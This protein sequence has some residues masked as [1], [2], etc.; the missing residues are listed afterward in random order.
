[1]SNLS[2]G[3]YHSGDETLAFCGT[4]LASNQSLHLYLTTYSITA[5]SPFRSPLSRGLTRLSRKRKRH[6]ALQL[7]WLFLFALVALHVSISLRYWWTMFPG[8][9]PPLS[10]TLRGNSVAGTFNGAPLTLVTLPAAASTRVHCVGDNYFHDEN[11]AFTTSAWMQRSCHFTGLFCF[12]LTSH[13]FVVYQSAVEQSL[14]RLL[15]Q[16]KTVLGRSFHTSSMVMDLASNNTQTVSLG[17]L[18]QKWGEAGIRRLEW[19]PEVVNISSTTAPRVVYALPPSVVLLPFHS[20]NGANPGHAVWDDFM[21]LYT[22]MDIFDLL[23]LQPLLMRYVLDDGERGLWASC[24]LREDKTTACAHIMNKFSP[25]MMRR[26]TGYHWSTTKEP[27]FQPMQQTPP[28]D[29]VCSSNGA[30]GI[31][32]LTDHGVF[33]VSMRK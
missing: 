28:T 19:F 23:D 11:S 14:T 2:L 30:A 24:D 27:D 29:M 25:L 33:K 6:S 20:L 13:K 5:P 10:S 9:I 18:N 16:G 26:S 12:N 31:G 7:F 21:S 3:E 17:G 4:S 22:L 15:A 8:S 32:S 1:M